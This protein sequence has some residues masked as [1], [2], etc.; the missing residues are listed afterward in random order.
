MTEKNLLSK[1]LGKE[2]PIRVLQVI[3]RLIP[4]GATD[5]TLNLC[6]GLKERGFQVELAAAPDPKMTETVHK[7]GV[8]FHPIPEFRRE[9]SPVYDFLA[10]LKLYKLI[11][12]GGYQIVHTRTSKA[13]ILG[14]LAARLAHAPVILHEPQGSIFHP[15][16]FSP[17]AQWFF[18]LVERLAATWA[19]KIIVLCQSE[20]NDYLNHRIA[21]KEKYIVIRAVFD[22]DRFRQVWVNVAEKKQELGLP[23]D[24]FVIG[25]IARLSPEKGHFDALEAFQKVH[26]EIPD[27]FLLIV[28]EGELKK[29]IRQRVTR[30]GIEDRVVMAGYR[31]DIPEITRI[32]DI[33]LNP[34]LWDCSPRSI[35]EAVVCGVPVVATTVGGIPEM[36]S[37]E[38]SGLLVP[39]GDTEAM[40]HCILRLRRDEEL[41]KRL[42]I[43]A[44]ERIQELFDPVQTI[45]RTVQLYLELLTEKGFLGE[46]QR[47]HAG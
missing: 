43:K 44:A 41:R 19:D 4:G 23:K 6:R 35:L 26:K 32:L 36:V 30:M 20:V 27:A 17:P 21:P 42:T 15:T 10:L 7:T 11:R 12:K 39:T 45:E 47:I 34:S 33:S 46:T 25:I 40:A 9:I 31:G 8:P 3:T 1:K 24:S 22:M 2:T 29:A 5:I 38:E 14:R 16:F 28:G 18:A 37:N 13:G